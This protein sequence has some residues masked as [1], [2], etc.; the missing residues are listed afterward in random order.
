MYVH[1]KHAVCDD[2]TFDET[3]ECVSDLSEMR[4]RGTQSGIMLDAS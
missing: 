3:I 1:D 4:F 2:T